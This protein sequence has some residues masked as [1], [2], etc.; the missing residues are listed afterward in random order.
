MY[1]VYGELKQV[2]ENLETFKYW[3]NPV[4]W[5]VE[6]HKGLYILVNHEDTATFLMAGTIIGIWLIMVDVKWVKKW[7]FWS[8]VGYWILRGFV[9]RNGVA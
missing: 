8:W 1:G 7:L 5:F 6:A 4:N 9:Y 2:N 3:I